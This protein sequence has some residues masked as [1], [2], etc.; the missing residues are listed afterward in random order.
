MAITLDDIH[1]KD[2]PFNI[3]IGAGSTSLEHS[4]YVGDG[5]TAT[6]AGAVTTYDVMTKD[7]YGNARSEAVAEAFNAEVMVV[8]NGGASF[9]TISA[10]VVD[11]GDGSLSLAAHPIRFRSKSNSRPS[12]FTRYG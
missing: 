2:S 5:L 9:S 10:D 8:V 3:P 12:A 1:I 11:N 7:M 6:V 4:E